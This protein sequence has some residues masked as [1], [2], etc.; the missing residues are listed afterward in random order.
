MIR[1]EASL[2]AFIPLPQKEVETGAANATIFEPD[3]V[4]GQ[5]RWIPKA[6]ENPVSIRINL[7][8]LRPVVNIL[9]AQEA[10]TIPILAGTVIPAALIILVE[11]RKC[12]MNT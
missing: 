1:T 3:E 5:A 6:P 2:R 9:I 8:I 4:M 12:E 7:I 11:A 10:V